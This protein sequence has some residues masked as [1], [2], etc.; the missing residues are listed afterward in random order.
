MQGSAPAR[1]LSNSRPGSPQNSA[2]SFAAAN[3]GSP[4][5][6]KFKCTTCFAA[7]AGGLN[8][9]GI[10]GDSSVDNWV[11]AYVGDRAGSYIE[12]TTYQYVG[13][14]AGAY[15]IVPERDN[16]RVTIAFAACGMISLMLIGISWIALHPSTTTTSSTA[17]GSFD[18][19]AGYAKWQTGWSEMKK[20]Y[21]CG[22]GHVNC[23]VV[24]TTVAPAY[25]C[26]YDA[27]QHHLWAL[28][29]KVWCCVHLRV[30]CPTV[31]PA[32]LQ[33]R[34]TTVALIQQQ[35]SSPFD[36]NSGFSNWL[37]GWSPPKKSWCC[38]HKQRGCP[39][40]SGPPATASTSAPRFNCG[41]GMLNWQ[42]G[43]PR[44]KKRWCC[45][46][47]RIGCPATGE[48]PKAGAY[49]CNAGVDN[50]LHG[51]SNG[52]KAWCCDTTGKGCQR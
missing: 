35:Y 22:V 51:W 20:Y 12:D 34:S 36:C 28:P 21:C 6:G 48:L 52:K 44:S 2:Q 23:N 24:A 10:A 31:A 25:D 18:C 19:N 26:R 16:T 3:T 15:D 33:Q 49:D 8:M 29:K 41:D 9:C 4:G 14:G 13:E 32:T 45:Q 1:Q 42:A 5:G 17:R 37:E 50:W 40:T 38:S 30:G 46:H 47:A 39:A 11:P 43:W 27:E 7:N